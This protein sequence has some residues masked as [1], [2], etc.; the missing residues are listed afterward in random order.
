MRRF[1]QIGIQK[2]TELNKERFMKYKSYAQA[3]CGIRVSK[4]S[5]KRLAGEMKAQEGHAEKIF[6]ETGEVTGMDFSANRKG[7]AHCCRNW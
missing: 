3:T 1:W 4:G 2:I 5:V 7:R 6:Q